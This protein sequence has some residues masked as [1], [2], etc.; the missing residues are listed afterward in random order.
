MF[1]GIHLA[2]RHSQKCIVCLV[3]TAH[4]Q[5]RIHFL[6]IEQ[7]TLNVLHQISGSSNDTICDKRAHCG[8]VQLSILSHRIMIW[9]RLIESYPG[10][11]ALIKLCPSRCIAHPC[12]FSVLSGGR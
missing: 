10:S 2:V 5:Q 11:H 4:R 1:D 6:A 8:K 9:L 12:F 3:S 7:V